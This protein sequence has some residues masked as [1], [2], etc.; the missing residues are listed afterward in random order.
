MTIGGVLNGLS[1]IGVRLPDEVVCMAVSMCIYFSEQVEVNST[2]GNSQYQYIDKGK[3][4]VFIVTNYDCIVISCIGFL[5]QPTFIQIHCSAVLGS[6]GV[7]G[8]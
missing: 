5:L 8:L 6:Q 2:K 3:R 1:K 7:L 4:R